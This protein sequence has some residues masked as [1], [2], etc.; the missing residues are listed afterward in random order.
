LVARPLREQIAVATLV[1]LVPLAAVITWAAGQTYEEQ[2]AQVRRESRA[3]AVVIAA[4]VDVT[5]PEDDARL[6]EFLR[7]MALP[8]EGTHI[9][10]IEKGKGTLIAERPG[11]A[12]YIQEQAPG[13]AESSRQP[14]VVSVG[15]PTSIAW[16]RTGEVYKRSLAIAGIATLIMLAMEAVFVRRW[17]KALRH[18]EVA[19]ERVGAGDLRTP[20]NESMPSRELEHLHVAFTGMVDNLH[21]ARASIAR[22]VEEE[23][24]MREEVESLQLQIIRQ[25][26]LA[27]IGT[28]LSGIAHELNNPL[29]AISGFAE[30]LQRDPDLKPSVIADLGLIRKESMRASGIIRNLSRF[31]RQQA[32]KPTH[33]YLRDVIGSVI[34]LRQRYF[35]E[36]GIVC[37]VVDDAVASTLAVF[38]ELQQVLLNFVLNAEHAL[39]AMP[40]DQRAITIRTSD[41]GDRVRLDVQDSGSGVPPEHESKLFQPFFTTKPMGEGTGLGLSVRY[42]IIQASGGTIGYQRS[43]AGGAAFYFELPAA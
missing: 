10:I 41:V 19:A 39:A 27:A 23:R 22:Q 24:R 33:V 26:R 14:W 38:T 12:D 16:W 8:D 17:L 37:T 11:A 18:F 1:L 34:E 36:Q 40:R 21:D 20:A 3:L 5:G 43:A 31:S 30:L 32:T 4:H 7:M 2:L 29:Q 42:G 9:T 28:L 6:N 15:V 25:E 13:S 35:L